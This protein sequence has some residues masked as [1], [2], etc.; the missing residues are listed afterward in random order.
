[1]D[2]HF[3]SDS[4]HWETPQKVTII[5]DSTCDL[6][7]DILKT[8][9]IESIPTTVMFGTESFLD[10][11]TI[12]QKEF[13]KMLQ[14]ENQPHPTTGA[15]SLEI[16]KTIYEK[17]PD[18]DIISIHVAS[19]LSA[20]HEHAVLAAKELNTKRISIFDSETVSLGLG[21]M[22]L[23]AIELS[24]NGLSVTDILSQ[25]E[26]MKSQTSLYASLNTL[27]YIKKGGRISKLKGLLGSILA[28]KPI[29]QIAHNEIV[30][31]NS[32]IRKRTQ[33]LQELVNI[34]EHHEP[35]KQVG[36]VH[37]DAEKEAKDLANEIS[38]FFTGK[39]LLSEI[40]PALTVHAGPKAIGIA[41]VQQ[42]ISPANYM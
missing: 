39:I 29:L 34:A 35:L 1:M 19:K 10:K 23:K 22:V 33:S 27:E 17:H 38:K 36:V 40:G 26:Y 41:L 4:S 3:S 11:V 12:T 37:V 25:L 6:P 16:Y 24:D 14:D 30:P 13:L 7:E 21:F 42:H 9:N 32:S 2:I 20:I 28:F 15:S 31:Y 18:T 8:K 5:T